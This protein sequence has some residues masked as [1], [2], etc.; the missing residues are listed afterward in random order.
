VA[1]RGAILSEFRL[2]ASPNPKNFPRRNRIISGLSLGVLVVEAGARSGALITADWALEQ[3]REVFALPGRLD[4]PQSAGCHAL[5][6]QGAAKLVESLEDVLEELTGVSRSAI[7]PPAASPAS[8]GTDPPS[9]C[10][11]RDE[12]RLLLGLLGPEPKHIDLLIA[13]S[14]LASSTV[15]AALLGLE[16]RR[17]IRQLPGKYFVRR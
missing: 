13:E 11:A 5:I 7:A 10:A 17:A 3:G 8:P 9:R 16:L 2:N 14:R 4:N 6:K 1:E 12:E 15:A